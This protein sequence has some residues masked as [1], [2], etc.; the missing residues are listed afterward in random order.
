MITNRKWGLRV[1]QDWVLRTLR[2]LPGPRDEAAIRTA[3]ALRD[4]V[5]GKKPAP[6]AKPPKPAP[7]PRPGAGSV[8]PP[9]GLPDVPP[10]PTDLN[11]QLPQGITGSGHRVRSLYETG[12]GSGQV[13]DIDLLEQLNAEYQDRRI[14][15]SPPSYS[16]TALA[17][18]ARRRVGWVNDMV[19]LAG[20]RTLEIGCGNGF[21]VWSLAHNLGCDAHG[22]DVTHYRPWDQLAGDRVHFECADLS[23]KSPYEPDSF[24]R[25]LSFTVWEHVTHPYAML[26]ATYDL[27]KPGGLAWIRANLHAGPQASH[28]YRDIYFPWPHLLF[29]DEVVRAWDV[30]HGRAPIGHAWVNRLSWLHYEYYADLLGFEVAHRAFTQSPI[31]ED[32]YSRFEDVL[33]RYPRADLQRDYFLLV[34][35]KPL[36]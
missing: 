35:R 13:Y 12:E 26:K 17:E 7:K 1:P 28:R 21:E 8:R 4:L 27:L 30:K 6:F 10:L 11:W 18:A 5:L 22:V 14:V 2:G 23:V 29:T 32:F 33:G 31:D 25:V 9:T 24:D 19:G 20:K 34:L 36:G 3:I 15:P 16:D